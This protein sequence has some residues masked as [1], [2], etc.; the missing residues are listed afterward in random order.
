LYRLALQ[1][2]APHP[3]YLSGQLTCSQLQGWMAYASIEPF[4]EYRHE[5][6]HGQQMALHCNINRDSKNKP[7]PYKAIDFMNFVDTPPERKLTDTEI[8]AELTRIFGV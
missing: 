4:G 1:L 7:E 3:D 8:E 5:L 6:R 2:G